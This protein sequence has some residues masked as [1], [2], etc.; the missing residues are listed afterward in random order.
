MTALATR[1]PPLF[2]LG[3]DRSGTSLLA[4]LLHRWGAHAGDSA[5]LRAANAGNPQ[6]YWE[7]QPMQD[8]LA[9]LITAVGHSVWDPRCRELMRRQASD[10]ALRRRALELAAAMEHPERP[11]FWKEPNF[12]LT[13]P[14][15]AEIFTDAVYLIT[16]RNP[17]DSLA[18]Y[19]QFFLPPSLAG[20]IK[21]GGYF[22]L[23]WQYFAVSICAEL[24]AHRRQLLVVYEELVSS[25]LPQCERICRFLTAA[26]GPAFAADP[27]LAERMAATVSPR[28]WRNNGGIPF[29]AAAHASPAQK[30]LYSYLSSHADS[31]FGDFDPARYP[32]PECFEEYM[33]NMTVFK[34]LFDN[35]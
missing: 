10:P 35:M 31:D 3:V 6:G 15:W 7:Y 4:E 32:F 25:P 21:I 11:W 8:F 22:F 2:V 23:R 30:E 34:W 13:L 1:L 33:S 27:G 12:V 9:E 5:Q 16:L 14:F 17:G 29:A 24:K 19:E 28:L 26:Y 18:S 20:K